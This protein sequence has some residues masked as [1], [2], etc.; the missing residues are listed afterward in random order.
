[1]LKV[2]LKHEAGGIGKYA[3]GAKSVAEKLTWL[4]C[5]AASTI[6]DLTKFSL[7][8]LNM[9]RIRWNFQLA[10]FQIRGFTFLKS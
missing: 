1:M 2:S 5:F 8:D 9:T 4:G 3:V 6:L 10:Y 7:I